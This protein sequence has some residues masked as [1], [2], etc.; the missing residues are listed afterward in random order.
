M[1]SALICIPTIWAKRPREEFRSAMVRLTAPVA[2]SRTTRPP[3]RAGATRERTHG[4]FPT[5]ARS[6]AGALA[7][8]E[9]SICFHFEQAIERL[10]VM[11]LQI[12]VFRF[13]NRD[14][15]EPTDLLGAAV[16]Q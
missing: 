4:T 14:G 6:M 10:R 11:R 13:G 8:S 2:A 15:E 9:N 3:L 12:G 1:T 16:E 7:M 5:S